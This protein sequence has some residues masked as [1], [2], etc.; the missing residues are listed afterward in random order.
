MNENKNN[1]ASRRQA[2]RSIVTIAAGSLIRPVSV[3]GLSPVKNKLRFSVLGDW[4]TGDSNCARIADQ[5]TL[6]HRNP[7]Q[8]FYRC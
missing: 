5:I 1:L 8:T 3:F 6:A 2:V 7:Q 4:G